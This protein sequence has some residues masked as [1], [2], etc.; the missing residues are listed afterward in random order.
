MNTNKSPILICGPVT[1]G[2]THTSLALARNLD[3]AIINLDNN[4]SCKKM[5]T[6]EDLE[7]F[8]LEK[9]A[10]FQFLEPCEDPLSPHDYL[11]RVKREVFRFN[12][13][14]LRSIIHG[15][16]PSYAF[17]AMKT[18]SDKLTFAM[19]IRDRVKLLERCEKRVS[20]FFNDDT[21]LITKW[22]IN[23]G[24]EDCFA[25]KTNFILTS[26]AKLVRKQKNKQ[27]VFDEMV[28]T[29]LDVY[30]SQLQRY[31]DHKDL[32]WIEFDPHN[33][34]KAEQHIKEVILSD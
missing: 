20:G 5:V 9:T 32:Q 27:F 34:L 16:T 3:C 25:F 19:C 1:T 26:M 6:G 14:E 24:F 23:Q 33:P 30:D 15:N 21:I 7:D 28:E 17:E 29:M 22:A 2:K 10:L 18:V 31:H 8:P 12:K 11:E 13:L 4:F